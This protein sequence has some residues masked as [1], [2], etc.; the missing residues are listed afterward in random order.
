[1]SI[2]AVKIFYVC[3]QKLRS[4]RSLFREAIPRTQGSECNRQGSQSS[5]HALLIMNTDPGDYPYRFITLFLSVSKN[6]GFGP[7]NTR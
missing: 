7:I 6:F 4:Q 3:H 1:M 5:V 2:F